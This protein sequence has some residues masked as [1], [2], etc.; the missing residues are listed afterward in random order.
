MNADVVHALSS[1]FNFTLDSTTDGPAL[2]GWG[3]YPLT[4]SWFD[5]NA[6]FAGLF[7]AIVARDYDVSLADWYRYGD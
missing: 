2:S 4:G 3:N 7:G 6:T 5:P 1:M